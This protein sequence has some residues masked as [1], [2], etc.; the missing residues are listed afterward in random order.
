MIKPYSIESR[1]K[2]YY[3][4]TDC[5]QLAG[6]LL[7]DGTM[8]NFSDGNYQRDQ[9]HR[10]IGYF[11]TNALGTNAL[12][13]FLRRG[14]IRIMC[15]ENSYNFEYYKLPTK[16]QFRQLQHAYFEFQKNIK[17]NSSFWI[18]KEIRTNTYN[19]YDFET[20][21]NHISKYVDYEVIYYV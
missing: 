7:Q 4:L 13:K 19:T 15:H 12:R 9:D 14:N 2:K 6:Y 1:A 10:N 18:E 11:Y 8:L 5:F 16:E 17:P 3:G 21:C 20:F